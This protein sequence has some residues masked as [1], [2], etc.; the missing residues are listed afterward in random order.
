MGENS[1]RLYFIPVHDVDYIEADGNYVHIHVGDQK[2]VR[3]DTLK[4]LAS[5]LR[6][7]EFEY[8]RRSR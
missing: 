3:R 4:R 6:D 2:Y 8:I 1:Q 5:A 7:A